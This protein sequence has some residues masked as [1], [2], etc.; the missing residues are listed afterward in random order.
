MGEVWKGRDTRLNRLV[1]IKRLKGSHSARFAQEARAIAAVNHPNICQIFDIGPDYL[2]L[3]YVEGAPLKGP[4]ANSDIAK[5]AADIAGA[6]EAAHAKG[7]LH[8]DLKPA[9]IL[10]TPGGCKLLD[11]GLARLTGDS[12]SQRETRTA[13]GTVAG[14][15]AYMSPEQAQG[16]TVDPRSD[17]FSFGAVLYEMISGRR[18]FP[19]E[20]MLETLSAVVM[21]EPP[22]LDSPLASV[23]SRC[24][25]KRP[26]L[27]FQ[28]AAELKTALSGSPAASPVG[29]ID[30]IAVLPFTNNANDPDAEYLCEGIAENIMNTLAQ[31]PRLR[32]APRSIV[33]RYKSAD[34]DPQAI[35]RQLG[36]RAVLTGRVRQR[37]DNLLVGAE[38]V[39]VAAGAQLW[40]ERFQRKIADL[41]D[42]EE[43]IAVKIAQGLRAKLSSSDHAARPKRFTSNTEAY[44]LYLRGRHHW[45]R[46]APAEVKKA[47]EYFQQAIDKDPGYALAYSG[48]ADCYS[49][50]AIYAILPQKEGFSRAKAAAVAATAFDD[51]LAEA[52]TSLAFIRGYFEYDWKAAEA[53]YDRAHELNPSY[54]VTP[55]WHAMMLFSLERYDQAEQKIQQAVELEPFSP[56]VMHLAV[57]IPYYAGRPEVAIEYG[58]RGIENHPYFFLIRYWLGLAYEAVGRHE[59]A[60]SEL[61]KAVE[62]SS[63]SVTW[64]TGGLA[65]AYASAGRRAEAEAI[66]R[67]LL[68]RSEHGVV[69]AIGVATAYLALGDSANALD[70]IERGVEAR[71]MLPLMIK[72]NP[73]LNPLRGDPRFQEALRRMNLA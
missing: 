73:H 36:V 17:I 50:L 16:Q 58:I 28:S 23:V 5:I 54:W 26:D 1:A 44:Q 37:G 32:V 53:E 25:M 12:D 13:E 24:L 29:A 64:V 40:G 35:G 38:L 47:A 30:S 68:D 61:E 70:W 21:S 18:A 33:F 63:R 7:I 20:S 51:E 72:G 71:G 45:I 42:L 4:L 41:F 31:A 56:T 48:L 52:H 39:D 60:V 10:L 57:A 19:G 66:L 43:E 15:A 65:H 69:D 67:E 6:L 11:F 9:N 34:A 14:T 55:Y 27:R 46:R 49:I 59:E 2:V 22:T 62:L 8:R 3:E